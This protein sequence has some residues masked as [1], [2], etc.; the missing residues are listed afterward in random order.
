MTNAL[1]QLKPCACHPEMEVAKVYNADSTGPCIRIFAINHRTPD[2]LKDQLAKIENYLKEHP[3][4][5]GRELFVEG[6]VNYISKFTDFSSC[7]VTVRSWDDGQYD[8]TIKCLISCLTDFNKHIPFLQLIARIFDSSLNSDFSY[9]DWKDPS[10]QWLVKKRLNDKLSQ[11]AYP[12][13]AQSFF[14]HLGKATQ[15]ANFIIGKGHVIRHDYFDEIRNDAFNT[16]EKIIEE[17]KQPTI[18]LE[19][20]INSI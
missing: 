19:P 8:N 15:G 11:E 17:K 14:S 5:E 10:T 7:N 4:A 2:I 18:I 16:F 9:A 3:E 13:R 20:T 12:L 1:S 6:T